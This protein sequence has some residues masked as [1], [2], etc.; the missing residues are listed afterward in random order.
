VELLRCRQIFS[1][2]INVGEIES[3]SFDTY[4]KPYDGAI[5]SPF[6]T[7]VHGIHTNSPEIKNAKGIEILWNEFVPYIT[8]GTVRAVILNGSIS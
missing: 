3:E 6:S 7:D 2:K 1:E 5:W 4:V 8:R